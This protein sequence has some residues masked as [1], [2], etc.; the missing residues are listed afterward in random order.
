MQARLGTISAGQWMCG[1][2]PAVVL[3][4]AATSAAQAGGW[5][6]FGGDA[7]HTAVS[8]VPAQ[9]LQRVRWSTP[10]DLQPQYSGTDLLIHYGTPLVT[11]RN[12]VLIPV[13]VGAADG[14]QV[15]ARRADNGAL[16]WME[17]T[18]YTLPTHGWVPSLGMTLTRH[19]RLIIPGAGGTIYRRVLPNRANAQR[20]RRAFYGI[21][22]YAADPSSFNNTVMIS[23][24]I[25][26][27]ARQVAYFG[28]VALDGAPLGLQSG[29]ARVTSG[30]DAGWVAAWTAA[31]DNSIKRVVYNCAPALSRDGKRLYIAVTDS[32]GAG[33]GAGYLLALDPRTLATLARV[34]LKDVRQPGQDASL[35]D[36]GTASPMVGPDGDVYFGVLENPLGSNHLRG[37]LLHFDA[38]LSQAKTPGAFGWDSTASS[39]PASAVPSYSGTAAYLL[40]TKYNNYAEAGG[41]GV[42]KF[43]ILD[44]NAT[45]T[46]PLSGATVMREVLTVT[47]PTPDADVVD[48]Q[49]PD[50]VMEWCINTGVVDPQ[51]KS[52]LINNEDGFM[53]R[54]DF[55]T[56]TL[57][58]A[59]QLTAG[60]FEAYTPTIIGP[61]GTTYGISNGILFAAG[62]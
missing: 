7:Q 59:V 5:Y 4:G 55:T 50:A 27:D 49:H 31:A 51:S 12:T 53:Y 1:M 56:N 62:R 60:L 40:M 34:R 45:M 23:T 22:Q 35:P 21:Q 11:R 33:F 36:D 61:D 30:R 13:K 9:P 16:V 48:A 24:P 44:P 47:A 46:D 6:G 39:V 19:E 43:A 32:G 18:D 28:F 8:A 52:A 2:L 3:L 20:R 26:A 25:T 41:D 37:W 58:A 17:P 29:V 54:W 38:T 42:N 57:A 14:F 10:V 15:E